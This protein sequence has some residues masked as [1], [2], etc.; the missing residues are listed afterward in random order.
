[1]SRLT[2]PCGLLPTMV[3]PIGVSVPCV[4]IEN[5]A[6]FELP[7]FEAYTK[8]LLGVMAFQQLAAPK[9]GTL[10]LT[11]VSVSL[12][13]TVSD[14]IA[15]LWSPPAAPVSETM[16]LPSGAKRAEKAPAPGLGLITAG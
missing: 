11:A 8:L 7:A 12:D 4:P 13:C 16:S 15:E 1:M 2:L 10:W 14:E 9:V 6:I 5:P 3:L